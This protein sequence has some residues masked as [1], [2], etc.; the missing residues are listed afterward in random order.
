[1]SNPL[2][3]AMLALF[4]LLAGC[5][6]ESGTPNVERAQIPASA[7]TIMFFGGAEGPVVF[8]HEKHSSEYY[9]GVCIACHDHEAV[10]GVTHWY[11]RDCHTAGSDSEALCNPYDLD[12]GCIMA[13]CQNCHLLEGPPA[14]SGVSC[15]V[16]ASGCHSL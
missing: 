14:P 6:G 10:A 16:A 2:V 4:A 7:N 5:G 9:G 15:G 8:T 3:A 11:C 13:Q 1:M 12:H